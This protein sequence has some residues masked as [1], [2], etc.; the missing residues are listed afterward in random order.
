MTAQSPDGKTIAIV[1][2]NPEVEN[3]SYRLKINGKKFKTIKCYR[4][5][6]NEDFATISQNNTFSPEGLLIDLK[7]KSIT[8]I[9]LNKK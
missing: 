9:V 2:V 7:N 8:S 6:E 5:S 1:I 4:T 3:K